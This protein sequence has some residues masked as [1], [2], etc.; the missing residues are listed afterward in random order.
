MSLVIPQFAVHMKT[1]AVL[2][3]N[4]W[5]D[6]FD[7]TL[8]EKSKRYGLCNRKI[9]KVRMGRCDGLY[10]SQGNILGLFHDSNHYFRKVYGVVFFHTQNEVDQNVPFVKPAQ[11]RVGMNMCFY[12][13]VSSISIYITPQTKMDERTYYIKNGNVTFGALIP[14]KDSDYEFGLN[15]TKKMFAWDYSPQ[16][17]K[18]S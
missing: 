15:K 2:T 14:V 17:L 11:L 1:S 10:V 3:V 4:S 13:E 8:P 7:T 16:L 5:L 12:E 6:I 9:A 18:I